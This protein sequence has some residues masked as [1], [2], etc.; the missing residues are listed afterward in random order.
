[1]S[2]KRDAVCFNL[3]G[4]PSELRKGMEGISKDHPSR[5]GTGR[6]CVLLTF[7]RDRNF[8][9][10][11]YVIEGDAKALTVKYGSVSTAFRALGRLL[12]E[13]LLS[14]KVRISESSA[15][16]MRGLMFDCSRNGV[17]NEEMLRTVMRR[18]SLMGINMIML[19]CEDTYEIPGE[20]YFGYLRGR[21]TQKELK[22]IDDYAHSLG[23][24]MVPCI[25]ALAHLEQIIQWPAYA[26]I[27]DTNHILL[28]GEK[29]TYDFVRKMIRAASAP[30]RSKR[31]HIGMDEAHGLGTG[32]YKRRHGER[33]A[34]DIMNEHLDAVRKIC[35]KEGLKPMI[36][37]DMYFRLGSKTHAY[38]DKKWKIPADVVKKIPSGVELVYW[39]YYHDKVEAYSRM[40][41]FH[42]KLGSTPIVAGG[43][44]TWGL[45]WCALRWS[46]KAMDACL[47]ACKKDGIKEVFMTMWGDDGMECD[48]LSALPG[49][50]YF[51]ERAFDPKANMAVVAK[52]FEAICGCAFDP[53]IDA[54]GI[55]T[56]PIYKDNAMHANTAKGLV[57]QDPFYPLMEAHVNN[58]MN[59]QPYYA[60][61]SS[62][63]SKESVG[64]GLSDRLAYPAAMAGAIA[65][66]VNLRKAL[67]AAYKARDRK[68]LRRLR[69]TDLR[70]ARR[71]MEKLWKQH[72]AMWMKTYKPFGWEVIEHRYGGV[73]ARFD[74]LNQRLTDYLDRKISALPELDVKILDPWPKL[75]NE[76]IWT[77]HARVKTASCIK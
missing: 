46:F 65:A 74:T 38:Y 45:H 28:V 8:P 9:A 24:E 10:D 47:T 12:S 72:R 48:P 34:F 60:K 44:W 19:Y 18:V 56:P 3:S 15:L 64:G 31:I 6:G 23:I 5:F 69:D 70:L 54:D 41:G 7:R 37:S 59:L 4:L 53:W 11:G 50:Q 58:K 57:Y 42:R 52:R 76:V 62:Y 39:D 14:G 33:R 51:C 13:K 68:K 22:S 30:F 25:Q 43:I 71:T 40:I 2:K 61:L 66:R 63:L 67:A 55:N 73:M 77:G 29:K 49:I 32:E 27:C 1:M 17:M 26:D 16:T 21:Y 36:W 75:K 35:S 20:P